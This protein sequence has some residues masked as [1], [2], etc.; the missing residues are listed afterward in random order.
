MTSVP[1]RKYVF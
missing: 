1:H